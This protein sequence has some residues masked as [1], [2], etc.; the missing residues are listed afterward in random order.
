[1]THCIAYLKLSKHPDFYGSR[2]WSPGGEQRI[3]LR[4]NPN[5]KQAKGAVVVLTRLAQKT[6]CQALGWLLPSAFAPGAGIFALQ[7]L[8]YGLHQ[9]DAEKV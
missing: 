3:R 9:Q 7:D 4:V 6:A 1:V 8:R 5:E 2:R